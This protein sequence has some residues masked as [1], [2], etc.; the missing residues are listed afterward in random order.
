MV[1]FDRLAGEISGSVL[2][3]Y[4]MATTALV[5]ALGLALVALGTGADFRARQS[6]ETVEQPV[7]CATGGNLVGDE[8]L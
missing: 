1:K 5:L 7:P 6:I 3:D 2:P 4:A 8:C